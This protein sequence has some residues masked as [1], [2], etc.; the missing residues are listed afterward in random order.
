MTKPLTHAEIIRKLLTRSTTRPSVTLKTNHK[1]EVQVEVTAT[2]ASVAAAGEQAQAEF[3]RLRDE[4][5]R[6][7]D[8]IPEFQ[9]SEV[10][11]Q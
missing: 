3:D 9:E 8:F 11:F 10:P 6:V 4:Y 2:A 1:G 7:P 5:Q